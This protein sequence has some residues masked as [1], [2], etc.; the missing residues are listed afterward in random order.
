MTATSSVENWE[1]TFTY[2]GGSYHVTREDHRWVV[3][4]GL[5]SEA[6]R[7]F[8][9]ALDALSGI[10]VRDDELLELVVRLFS[11]CWMRLP[12]LPASSFEQPWGG[13]GDSGSSPLH[14]PGR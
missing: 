5:R 9:E 7:S 2:H 6:K 1:D 4:E 13:N 11:S 3:S 14:G 10:T 12:A 8:V